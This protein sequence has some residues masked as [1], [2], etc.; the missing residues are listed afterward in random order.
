MARGTRR[1]AD[2]TSRESWQGPWYEAGDRTEQRGVEDAAGLEVEIVSA[3]RARRRVR[4]GL[5]ERVWLLMQ[6]ARNKNLPV[7]SQ[8]KANVSNIV[9]IWAE[10]ARDIERSRRFLV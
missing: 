2:Q 8:D 3:A 6:G 10:V 5:G 7:G 1:Q 9:G 4:P